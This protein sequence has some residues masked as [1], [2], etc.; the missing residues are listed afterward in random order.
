[1]LKQCPTN[2]FLNPRTRF[3]L[4]E[5]LHWT[6]VVFDLFDNPINFIREFFS[7][8]SFHLANLLISVSLPH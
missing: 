3:P 6:G 7:V 2:I 1:M 5:Y 8:H 4:S